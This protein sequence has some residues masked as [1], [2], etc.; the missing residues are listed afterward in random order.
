MSG[1]SGKVFK[2]ENKF[3]HRTFALKQIKI[4]PKEDLDKV[5]KEVENL[6]KVKT[7]IV[8]MIFL[9]FAFFIEY[10]F[11]LFVK[12]CANKNVVKYL[13]CFLVQDDVLRENQVT[14]TVQMRM[15]CR[16]HTYIRLLSKA[17]APL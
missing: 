9:S 15:I 17:L 2:V 13:D 7:K 10:A 11:P 14:F 8:K 12:V 6:S 16:R 4:H 5:L 3:D 1:H